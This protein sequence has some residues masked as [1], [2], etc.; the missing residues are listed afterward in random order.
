MI[1]PVASVTERLEAYMLTKGQ[2][3]KP[4]GKKNIRGEAGGS[5]ERCS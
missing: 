4:S 5:F 3:L 2:V 1:V